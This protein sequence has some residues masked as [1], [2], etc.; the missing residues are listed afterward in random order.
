M[1]L[2]IINRHTD[3][4]LKWIRTCQGADLK[5]LLVPPFFNQHTL[6]HISLL[7]IISCRKNVTLNSHRGRGGG[8][9]CQELF[10]TQF[11][12]ATDAAP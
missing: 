1:V 10:C 11:V 12:P 4:E 7:Q 5:D 2:S 9:I 6:H 8:A 3:S